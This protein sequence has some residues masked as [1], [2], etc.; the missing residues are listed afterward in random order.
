MAIK[1][2]TNNTL[3]TLLKEPKDWQTVLN[4]GIYRIRGSLRHPPPM[5]TEKRVQYL[6]FYLPAAFGKQKFSVRHYAQ[7]KNIDMAPRHACIPD[8]TRNAKSND[9]YWKIDVAEPVALAEP[10][11][12]LR[13]R[14]YMVL[15]QTNEQR[16]LSAKEFNFLYK[17]SHLE[18]PMF[19]ALIDYNIF[20]E[21]EY[22]VT[23]NDKTAYFLDFAIFC[24]KGKFA[25]EMD[26]RQHQATRQSVINDHK[27]DNKLKHSKWNVM[28]FFEEDIA[29]DTIGKTMKEIVD[30]INEF[31]GLKTEDGLLPANPKVP[32]PSQLSFFHDE[33]LDFLALR[34]RVRDKYESG[35]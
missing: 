22:P 20:P 27:R 26:G 18:E 23:N 35:K 17:G 3:V 24:K 34:R 5:L 19:K 21:R 15:I 16:L 14:S 2:D 12:S 29:P 9:M 30:Y 1:T 8:E 7:V 31:G 25:I 13:G 32:N 10:I 33:H 4:H 6:G 11:V 28:R